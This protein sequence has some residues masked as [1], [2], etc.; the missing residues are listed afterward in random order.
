MT[1]PLDE[2]LGKARLAP[3]APYTSSDIDAAHQRL[4]DRVAA[5]AAAPAVPR[6][7]AVGRRSGRQELHT[8]CTLV[9]SEPN[10][11][12][13][14]VAFVSDCMPGTV[15]GRVLG[16]IL[17][18]RGRP[19]SARFW[20]QY[21]AGDGDR[22]ALYCLYL[23]HHAIGE[24]G[25]AALWLE[26]FQARCPPGGERSR[27]PA[28]RYPM[29]RLDAHSRQLFARM[30]AVDNRPVPVFQ[31]LRILRSLR[32]KWSLP[33][34]LDTVMDYV[35]AAVGWKDPDLDLPL[36]DWDFVTRVKSLTDRG[37]A[38]A[39]SRHRHT[40]DLETRSTRERATREH[41]ARTSGLPTSRGPLASC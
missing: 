7:A 37:A 14:L 27:L 33:D 34:G 35:A 10:A 13:D 31:A 2:L 5:R 39:S 36:P 1:D 18:L 28:L 21:A 11:V 20:W 38:T 9:V 30:R 32:V 15:G 19:E 41:A 29:Q 23:H 17:Y 3:T 25:E 40:R 22:A 8:L 16:S 6:K 26:Q 24:T 12:D 4:I